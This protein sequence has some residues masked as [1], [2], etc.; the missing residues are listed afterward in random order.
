[1]AR[2]RSHEFDPVRSDPPS[3]QRLLADLKR[4]QVL[5]VAAVYGATAFGVLQVAD[6]TFRRLGLP[7]WA[8]TLVPVLALAG[9]PFA[10]VLAW[11]Y[12][13]GPGGLRRTAP[14]APGELEAIAAEPR[15]R[16][17][18]SILEQAQSDGEPRLVW[19]GCD[20][21]F[22]AVRGSPRFQRIVRAYG[23][24]NGCRVTAN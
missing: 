7:D 14:A 17:W 3:W 4:R 12:D 13:A 21:T 9:L 1:M 22:D 15:A 10:L 2:T 24:P 16:R 20:H 5:R 11:A 23:L 8:V 6:L 19:L 18:L